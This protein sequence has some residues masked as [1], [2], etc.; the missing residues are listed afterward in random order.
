MGNISHKHLGIRS[1]SFDVLTLCLYQINAKLA[2]STGPVFELFF[3]CSN[4]MS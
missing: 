1:N 2:R 3:F 4:L